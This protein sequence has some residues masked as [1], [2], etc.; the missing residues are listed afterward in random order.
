MESPYIKVCKKYDIVSK[1]EI[2]CSPD[3]SIT[4]YSGTS[5][6]GN[7]ASGM[8][9]GRVFVKIF[10]MPCN[11]IKF[12]RNNKTIYKKKVQFDKNCIEM[13]I[14]NFFSDLLSTFITSN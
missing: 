4:N 1:H 14:T 3:L 12:E 5:K 7:S 11:Y 9:L 8:I 13:G 6:L 2:V 10:A